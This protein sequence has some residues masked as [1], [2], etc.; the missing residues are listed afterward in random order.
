[1]KNQI[2]VS[3]LLAP[4]G[5][6]EQQIRDQAESD[7]IELSEVQVREIAETLLADQNLFVARQEALSRALGEKV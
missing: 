2:S 3:E 4:T 6:D 7:G 5:I 1:M